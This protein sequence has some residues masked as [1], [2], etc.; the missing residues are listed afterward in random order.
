MDAINSFDNIVEYSLTPYVRCSIPLQNTS[1]QWVVLY[2]NPA[3]LKLVGIKSFLPKEALT[4]IAPGLNLTDELLNEYY[5][6]KDISE[7]R[8]IANHFAP[9]IK[10]WFQLVLIPTKHDEVSI[11]I[12]DITREQRE[13]SD[14]SDVLRQIHSF[15]FDVNETF[16]IERIYSKD[17]SELFTAPSALVGQ[18]LMSVFSDPFNGQLKDALVKAKDTAT[19]QFVIMP[20]IK[21][22]RITWW[23]LECD[24]FRTGKLTKF[25]IS[26]TDVTAEKTKDEAIISSESKFKSYILN[27]PVGIIVANE[28]FEVIQTNK[29]AEQVLLRDA[30]AIMSQSLIQLLESTSTFSISDR[31]NEMKLGNTIEFDTTVAGILPLVKWV[32]VLISKMNG[33]N[34]LIYLEDITQRKASEVR[35]TQQ[36]HYLSN[37]LNTTQDALWVINEFAQVIDCNPAACEMTGYTREVLIGK[38]ISFIDPSLVNLSMEEAFTYLKH[39]HSWKF[40]SKHRRINQESIDVEAVIT[41]LDYPQLSI[42]AFVR[43]ISD[44]KRSE[45][46]LLSQKELFK[47][48]LS[49]INEGVITTDLAGQVLWI[50]PVAS[51]YLAVAVEDSLGNH[52]DDV[53]LLLNDRGESVSELLIQNISDQ[54]LWHFN[55]NVNI[56]ANS[57][58]YPIHGELNQL[59][60]AQG[61]CVGAVFAFRDVTDLIDKMKQIEFLTMHDDLTGLYNRKYQDDAIRRLDTPRNYPFSIMAIDIINLKEMNT[62]HGTNFGDDVIKNVADGLKKLLRADDIVARMSGDEFELLLPHTSEEQSQGV[63]DRINKYFNAI[64]QPVAIGYATKHTEGEDIQAIRRLAEDKMYEN[65]GN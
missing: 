7:N 36:E 62:I 23:S 32:H 40:E 24:Y 10:R 35:I 12:D 30:A 5:Q 17:T 14:K 9:S 59:F 43:N 37:I 50:N 16:I 11:F 65:K 33:E 34:W 51:K 42:L 4:N 48:T 53:L 13:F 60:D 31:M 19:K 28:R 3:F 21:N 18:N 15:V 41:L 39:H 64:G 44:R 46:E 20:T 55:E 2:A 61:N 26:A 29:S 63:Y 56:F 1:S 49:T 8:V 27:A 45:H 38:P 54:K 6:K 47:T 22:N 57:I 25:F 58:A 52:I